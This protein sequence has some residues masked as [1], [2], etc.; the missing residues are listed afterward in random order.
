MTH[1]VTARRDRSR[2]L[3]CRKRRYDSERRAVAAHARAGFRVRAYLC[4]RCHGW[5]VTASQKRERL[6]DAG[7]ELRD[8]RLERLDR[9]RRRAHDRARDERRGA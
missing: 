8:A 6:D 5:H 9:E 1:Q 4:P 2:V 7:A 3:L